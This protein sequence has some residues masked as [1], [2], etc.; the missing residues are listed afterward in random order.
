MTNPLL[1]SSSNDLM[2][3]RNAWCHSEC[4]WNHCDLVSEREERRHHDC[5]V[6]PFNCVMSFT[7]GMCLLNDFLFSSSSKLLLLLSFFDLRYHRCCWWQF[8]YMERLQRMCTKKPSKRKQNQ[9]KMCGNRNTA[10]EWEIL[11][12]RG[13]SIFYRRLFVDLV[14]IDVD[15][16]LCMSS[17]V[18][19]T[20]EALK[21][22]VSPSF[23]SIM[24]MMMMMM[25]V[26]DKTC[27][28]SRQQ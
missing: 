7:R 11:K 18:V 24:M 22:G 23:L 27:E 12:R 16:N 19:L 6:T 9:Q 3:T 4:Y 5:E 15:D 1:F 21:R 14:V 25:I 13:Y 8:H 17:C 28:E 26:D 20:R 2:S 10:K